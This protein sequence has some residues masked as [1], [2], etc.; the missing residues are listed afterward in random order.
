MLNTNSVIQLLEC[1][2]H[3]TQVHR[4][5][6]L[7]AV[8]GKWQQQTLTLTSLITA[9]GSVWLAIACSLLSFLHFFMSFQTVCCQGSKYANMPENRR[10]CCT[11]AVFHIHK[12]P[13]S[14][15]HNL[16][17]SRNR[18]PVTYGWRYLLDVSSN[19]RAETYNKCLP[20]RS[21]HRQNSIE[22]TGSFQPVLL[23]RQ[24]VIFC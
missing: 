23:R 3:R 15:S 9:W 2:S 6:T 7:S 22:V 14:I 21:V 5:K 12:L 24:G 4:K 10:P 16:P 19:K 11:A 20:P 17:I 8:T 1:A 13:C 18:I